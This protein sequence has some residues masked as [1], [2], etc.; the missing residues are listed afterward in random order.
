MRENI[1]SSIAGGKCTIGKNI[2]GKSEVTGGVRRINFVAV[3][4]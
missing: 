3:Y 4:N 1:S 2:S